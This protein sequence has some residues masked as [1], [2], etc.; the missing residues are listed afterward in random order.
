MLQTSVF[1][2]L[3]ACGCENGPFVHYTTRLG[4]LDLM[5]SSYPS[6]AQ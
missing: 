5:C 1:C 2:L 6:R 4:L 3:A